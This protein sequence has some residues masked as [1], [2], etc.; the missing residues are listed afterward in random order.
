MIIDQ[1][2]KETLIFNSDHVYSLEE[3]GFTREQVINLY[4]DIFERFEFETREETVAREKVE[5]RK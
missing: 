1:A 4:P 5:V 3:M 2:V